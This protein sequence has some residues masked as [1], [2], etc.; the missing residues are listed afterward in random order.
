MRYLTLAAAILALAAPAHAQTALAARPSAALA[1][2][3]LDPADVASPEAIVRA[4]YA[5]ISGPADKPRDWAV[6]GRLFIPG[7]TVMP[8]SSRDGVK[9]RVLTAEEYQAGFKA[10]TA[11]YERGVIARVWRYAHIAT[12]DS[13]YV[14]RRTP[15]GAPYARGVNHF[16]LM[17][18]GARWWIVSIFWE[19]ET[20]AFPL[21]PEADALLK[22]NEGL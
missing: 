19:V 9:T 21:P 14:G 3:P 12:V 20:P 13:P 16:Q 11:L 2:S 6:I 4:A 8:T 15:D 5:A 17:F 18:D 7:A 22:S 1:P 10:G